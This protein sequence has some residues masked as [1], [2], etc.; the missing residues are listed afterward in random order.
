M[1]AET[2]IGAS[3][4]K[5]RCLKLLD[6]VAESGEG[7]TITKH[8]QPVARLVPVEAG[9]RARL[10]GGWEKVVRIVDDIVNTDTSEE[11]DAMR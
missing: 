7:L 2:M 6:D 3:E 1:I 5:A 10:F 8:G 11:W 4:F 9:R